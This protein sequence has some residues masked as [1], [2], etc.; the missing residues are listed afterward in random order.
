MLIQLGLSDCLQTLPT[1]M[2]QFI[3]APHSDNFWLGD[4]KL[5]TVY[6]QM[7]SEADVC[8]YSVAIKQEGGSSACMSTFA[9]I[10]HLGS[11]VA[12]FQTP[13]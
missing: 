8:V 12:S 11:G 13:S 2:L 7:L 3:A 4:C 6:P 5:Y 10:S 1:E 9:V